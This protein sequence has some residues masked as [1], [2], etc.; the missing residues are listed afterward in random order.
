MVNPLIQAYLKCV[1]GIH[2][3]HSLPG[4]IRVAINGVRQY[5]E[6]AAKFAGIFRDCVLKRPGVTDAELNLV[7]G[8]LL[9]RYDPNKT[10]EAEITVWL[11]SSWKAFILFL[12]GLGDVDAMD[13]AGVAAAVARFV[14]TL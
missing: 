4:R 13:E 10:C 5:P 14:A 1:G 6:L 11:D 3:V 9:V 2:V 7:T 8:N 12:N